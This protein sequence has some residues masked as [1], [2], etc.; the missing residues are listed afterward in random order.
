[1]MAFLWRCY[2]EYINTAFSFI[3]IF[4]SKNENIFDS[5]F[6]LEEWFV[7]CATFRI[8]L[9][10]SFSYK[11]YLWRRGKFRSFD[12]IFILFPLHLEQ[13][14]LHHIFS[15]YSVQNNWCG[16]REYVQCNIH[17]YYK[18]IVWNISCE[19]IYSWKLYSTQPR[20]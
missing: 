9:L 20:P 10:L 5:L 15:L 8:T 19:Y 4:F 1:M 3:F 14:L 18:R 2:V 12:S 6:K 13:I 11:S 17:I 7:H 16:I